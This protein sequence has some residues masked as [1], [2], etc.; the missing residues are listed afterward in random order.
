VPDGQTLVRILPKDTTKGGEF[1]FRLKDLPT[2]GTRDTIA[3]V[4]ALQPEVETPTPVEVPA[5]APS[6][7]ATPPNVEELPQVG[8]IYTFR[9]SNAQ[10]GTEVR[11][12]S[13][14]GVEFRDVTTPA[15]AWV[16]DKLVVASDG[17]LTLQLRVTEERAR[18]DV[19]I[20]VGE[21]RSD[22][23]YVVHSLP[24]QRVKAQAAKG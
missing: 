9:V 22:P 21:F 11:A 19:H 15:S 10:L 5:E 17:T 3:P 6:E 16:A 2:L 12:E 13:N 1:F 24:P 7:E 23:F 8:H 14:I 18:G 20:C 4:V